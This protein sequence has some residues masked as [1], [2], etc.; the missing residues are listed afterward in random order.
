MAD[1][2]R[3]VRIRKGAA[4]DIDVQEDQRFLLWHN[5]ASLDDENGIFPDD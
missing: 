1:V 3:G 4:R 2:K 5:I